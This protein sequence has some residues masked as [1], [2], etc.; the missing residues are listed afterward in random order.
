MKLAIEFAQDGKPYEASTEIKKAYT[1]RDN[2][3]H[4][5]DQKYDL[6]GQDLMWRAATYHLDAYQQT[7]DARLLAGIQP[8]LEDF[9][10]NHEGTGSKVSEMRRDLVIIRS[11]RLAIA[12]ALMETREY[13]RAALEAADCYW[14]LE[15]RAKA[16]AIGRRTA[17]AASEAYRHGW[18]MDNNIKHLHRAARIMDD[19]LQHAGPNATAAAKRERRRLSFDTGIAKAAGSGIDT[20]NPAS[21]Y[22]SVITR[23]DRAFLIVSGSALG[24]SAALTVTASLFGRK[25]FWAQ[26][27]LTTDPIEVKVDPGKMAPALTFAVISAAV[28][29]LA[30]H[31]MIDEGFIPPR[32]RKIVAALGTSI[33]LAGIIT[34]A[35][36]VAAGF[37]SGERRWANVGF[38]LATGMGAPLGAGISALVSRRGGAQ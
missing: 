6:V 20:G 11:E 35:A 9:L 18:N 10:E 21:S 38:G 15:T 16:E 19:H 7:K 1:L 13:L 34:G 24:G 32:E 27:V 17:I 29:G 31:G 26:Q 2:E 14:A 37:R 33:G 3:L 23:R 5:Y 12:K 28:S 36:L 4:S 8:I 30:I 25:S 22:T